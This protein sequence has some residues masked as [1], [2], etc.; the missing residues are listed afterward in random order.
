MSSN[1]NTKPT[2]LSIL[3]SLSKQLKVNEKL[4]IKTAIDLGFD[5]DNLSEGEAQA[6]VNHLTGTKPTAING[7]PTEPEP[8]Q[9]EE[10]DSMSL[11]AESDDLDLAADNVAQNVQNGGSIKQGFIDSEIGKTAAQAELLAHL[12]TAT[13]ADTYRRTMA[14]N[15]ATFQEISDKN[16]D[17]FMA[18][19]VD[20]FNQLGKG[21]DPNNL[22]REMAQKAQQQQAKTQ[23]YTDK[24]R[25]NFNVKSWLN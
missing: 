14:E 9:P 3:Q 24:I 18:S 7:K 12:N 4:I 15:M 21:T 23:A 2:Q 5:P 17:E 19:I 25:Q 16:H 6:I 1:N 20:K 8:A 10:L 11:I 13:F 22:P